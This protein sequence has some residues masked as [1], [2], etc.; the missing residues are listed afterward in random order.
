[1]TG[2]LLLAVVVLAIVVANLA[3]RLKAMARRLDAL[4]LERSLPAIAPAQRTAPEPVAESE[5]WTARPTAPEP[6]P[7]APPADVPEVPDATDADAPAWVRPGFESLIGARLPVWI[8]AVALMVAGFFLVSY[9]IESGL[10]G[11][12]V[13][14]F[15]AGAFAALLIVASEVAR[16]W[17]VTA[18]DPRVAQALAGAG[19]A[20]AY[21]A[22]YLAAALYRLV[23]PLPAFIVMLGVT[24]LA[25]VLALRHGPPTAVLA[26]AGGF[27]AP[28]VAGYDAAGIA[29]LLIYLALFTGALFALAIQRGW[30]WLAI[31]ATLAGFGWI[32]FLL[33][34]LRDA[35]Q[36][37]AAGFAVLLAIAASVALPRAGVGSP[38]LRLA[39][40]VAGLVQ[41]L[42]FAPALD[43]GPLA[44]AMYLTLAAA[45]LMLAWRDAQYL[46]GAIAAMVLA[47]ALVATG[48]AQTAPGVS[49]TGA[50]VAAAMFGGAGLA[51]LSRGR[52][53]GV[54]ALGGISGPLL[55]ANALA[56]DRLATWQW[57]LLGLVAAALAALVSWR[58]RAAT[59][60]GDPGLIGGALIA[61]VMWSAAVGQAVAAPWVPVV[62]AVATMAAG[63]WAWRRGDARL[64]ELPAIG[65]GAVA[66]AGVS[67]IVEYI[68]AIAISVWGGHLPFLSLPPLR[69]G[70][71]ALMPVVAV[72]AA[73][74]RDPGQFGRLRAVAGIAAT[75]AGLVLLWHLAKLPLAIGDEP[76]FVRR[77]LIERALISQ[78]L[79]AAGWWLVRRPGWGAIGVYLFALGLARI[80]WFDL[81]IL[82]PAIVEQRVGGWP[83]LNAAVVHMALAAIWCWRFALDAPWRRLGMA[84]ALAA[85]LALVR[86]AAH[87][88]VMTGPVLTGENYGYSAA[89]LLLALGWLVAGIRAQAR[90]LRIAG[91]VLLTGVTLKVFL[92]DAAALDGLLRVLSFLGLG[93]ALIGISWGYG[94]FLGAA[95]R[96]KASVAAD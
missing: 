79:L 87:G 82:N 94:R 5:Q 4:E 59:G 6:A 39:P 66:V 84:F 9:A 90:D 29:P 41:L 19:I 33:I 72:V 54:V 56:P 68:D 49:L 42:A 21:G 25:L 63:G 3:Q 38:W 83:V 77:G 17:R 81:L 44:W 32:N 73:L 1:M 28:L 70:V 24:A 2:L 48:L 85:M 50:A 43:F 13:R 11:P 26:L 64:F 10:L 89:L 80:C 22:L 96:P 46:P 34:V 51:L 93:I 58:R 75:V 57:T 7:A 60:T 91:L 18:D 65:L 31:A 36:G 23:P 14:T 86:Q 55:I 37:A 8:G 88:S 95:S 40:L 76:S 47:L 62:I 20:S 71:L 15:A 16:R 27:A 69:D 45:A 53:W 52:G 12:G 74:W 35:D 92:V 78:A 30:G 61:G 67:P